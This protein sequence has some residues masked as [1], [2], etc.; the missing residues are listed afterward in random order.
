MISYLRELITAFNNAEWTNRQRQLDTKLSIYVNKCPD[1][2]SEYLL[3]LREHGRQQR[4]RIANISSIFDYTETVR[5]INTENNQ[6]LDILD[7]SLTKMQP[8]EILSDL[9]IRKK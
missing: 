3:Y 2:I 5:K 4:E 7:D 6:V 9:Y 1:V 8:C